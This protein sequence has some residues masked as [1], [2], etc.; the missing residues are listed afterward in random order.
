MIRRT[1]LLAALALSTTGTTAEAQTFCSSPTMEACFVVSSFG[2]AEYA[3]AIP[4]LSDYS[5]SLRGHWTGSYFDG[6]T[7]LF[8]LARFD[9]FETSVLGRTVYL[10]AMQPDTYVGSLHIERGQAKNLPPPSFDYLSLVVQQRI[11]DTPAR[12]LFSCGGGCYQIPA[13]GVETETIE[14][15]LSTVSVPEP[16]TWLLLVT[17]LAGLAL[18]HRRRSF[19]H[20]T[21]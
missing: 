1:V 16:S 15:A 19:T 9:A 4:S 7:D 2:Y 6:L 18:A 11:P 8:W 13:P 10:R 20:R 12:V 21:A 17:G 5:M 14:S 3:S